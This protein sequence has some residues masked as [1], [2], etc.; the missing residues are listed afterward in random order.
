MSTLA[1]TTVDLARL[2]YANTS[3]YHFL[4]VPLTLGLA[5][6]VARTGVETTVVF[7]A[8]ASSSRPV[9]SSPRGVKVRFS[10]EGVIADDVIRDLA[11]AEPEGDVTGRDPGP[12]SRLERNTEV[13]IIVP[14]GAGS[15]VM[16]DVEGQSEDA[17]ISTLQS[18]GLSV[19]VLSVETEE[20]GEGQPTQTAATTVAGAVRRRRLHL[21]SG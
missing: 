2:Q 13:T 5:P 11:A 9:V 14:T 17:A 8:G 16:P 1:I 10:P 18:R 21:G 6:L 20:R 19:D 7:D 4:F 15:V 3:L 12:G